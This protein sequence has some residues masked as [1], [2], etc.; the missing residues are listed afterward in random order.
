[1]FEVTKQH[2]EAAAPRLGGKCGALRVV[3]GFI[4]PSGDTYVS[5]KLGR[6][7]IEARDR[8]EMVRL[9]TAHSSLVD[10]DAWDALM[11]HPSRLY[12]KPRAPHRLQQLLDEELGEGAVQVVCLCG[13]DHV[14]KFGG[15]VHAQPVAVMAR[16]GERLRCTLDPER[17]FVVN[18]PEAESSDASSTEARRRLREEGSSGGLLAPPVEQFLCEHALLGAE[19]SHSEWGG[20]RGRG[21]AIRVPR[22][23]H[24]CAQCS[25]RFEAQSSL[26]THVRHT[27]EKFREHSCRH[28]TRAFTLSC[29]LQRHTLCCWRRRQAAAAAAHTTLLT[30]VLAAGAQLFMRRLLR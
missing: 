21:G 6:D 15:W 11:W 1:M 22:R 20:A 10:V 13:V 5:Y 26:A 30:A 7:A 17:C 4:S 8:V 9:G 29:N 23:T 28:C 24:L 12:G 18:V 27:H 14:N 3:G 16:A 25:L 19:R 2:L